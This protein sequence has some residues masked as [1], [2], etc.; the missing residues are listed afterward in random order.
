LFGDGEI[1]VRVKLKNSNFFLEKGGK[2]YFPLKQKGE[3]SKY[4][5]N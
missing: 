3:N 2:N 4:A 5:R 1:F